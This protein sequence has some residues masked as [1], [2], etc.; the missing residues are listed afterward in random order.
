MYFR[1]RRYYRS[2]IS[3]SIMP[4]KNDSMPIRKRYLLDYNHFK[5]GCTINK[6]LLILLKPCLTSRNM[7]PNCLLNV[8]SSDLRSRLY[9]LNYLIYLA[10]LNFGRT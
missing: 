6:E 10:H 4:D 3:I 1:R 8:F 5:T 7:S 2:S 9:R